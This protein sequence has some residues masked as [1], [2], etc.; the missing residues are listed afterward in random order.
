MHGKMRILWQGRKVR[1]PSVPLS[2][3][4]E[5]NLEAQCQTG[6]SDCQRYSL[7]SQCL[8]TLPAFRQ[9]DSC[10][11]SDTQ[12]QTEISFDLR[13]SFYSSIVKV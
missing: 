2:Q 10:G 6:Q 11:L 9:G 8:H 5:Q 4:L 13:F 7:Q 12:K 3:T 1:Y